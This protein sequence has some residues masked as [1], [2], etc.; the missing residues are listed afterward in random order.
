MHKIY[1][2]GPLSGLPN[3]QRPALT[4][5]ALDGKLPTRGSAAKGAQDA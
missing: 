1:V 3:G 4:E 2:G 5:E